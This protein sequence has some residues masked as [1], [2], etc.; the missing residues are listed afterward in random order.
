ML[1]VY[2]SYVR[3]VFW[4]MSE[5]P[6]CD[7]ENEFKNNTF[8]IRMKISMKNEIIFCL[9]AVSSSTFFKVDEQDSTG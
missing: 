3:L 4:L 5:K 1:M 6:E 9:R 2:R 8:K 7:V